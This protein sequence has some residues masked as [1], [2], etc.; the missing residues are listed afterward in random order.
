MSISLHLYG[1]IAQHAGGKH[2]ATLTIPLEGTTTV[3]ELLARFSIPPEETGLVFINAVLHDLPGL[4]LSLDDPVHDGDHVGIFAAD[5]VW[6]YQY[7]GGAP[8]S[9]KLAAY[10]QTHD[11]LRHR[12][13]EAQ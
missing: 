12:P 10:T 11:Y 4:H 5:Y 6:P 7:R 3:R 13:R 2:I 8:M 9:S 1:T